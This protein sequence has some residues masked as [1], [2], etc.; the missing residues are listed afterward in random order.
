MP[1]GLR[2]DAEAGALSVRHEVVTEVRMPRWLERPPGQLRVC[3][4]PGMAGTSDAWS[5]HRVRQVTRAVFGLDAELIAVVAQPQ[6][7]AYREAFGRQVSF[8]GPQLLGPVPATCMGVVHEGGPDVTLTAAAHGAPNWCSP[9]PG[10]P[11]T[12]CAASARDTV[13][14][15]PKHR[16]RRT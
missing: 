14:C 1:P 9:T 4:R 6:R 5:V 11:A 16:T 15:W 13:S 2:T 7:Y 3:P 12:G 10:R 8:A